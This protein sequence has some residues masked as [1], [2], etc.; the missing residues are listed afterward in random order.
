MA[1]RI[2]YSVW[3]IVT[4]W[5]VRGPNPGGDQIFLCVQTGSEAHPPGLYRCESAGTWCRPSTFL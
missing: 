5:T 2:A 4:G 1:A 3:G